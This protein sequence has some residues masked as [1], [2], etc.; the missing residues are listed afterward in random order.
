MYKKTLH[1]HTKD[2]NLLMHRATI[3][4]RWTIRQHQRVN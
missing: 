3:N 1:E 4:W 2:A